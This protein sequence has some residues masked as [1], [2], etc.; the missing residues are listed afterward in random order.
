MEYKERVETALHTLYGD[1]SGKELPEYLELS[2]KFE[3]RFSVPVRHFFSSPGR[4]E[5]C[6]NH[7]DHNRGFVLAAAIDLDK[8]AAVAPRSDNI[9][10]IVTEDF[11]EEVSIDIG[12]GEI[13]KDEEG[14]SSSLVRGIAG[15]LR[16]KGFKTGGFSAYI[17]SRVAMGSGLSSSA[18]L[19]VLIGKIFSFLYND[20]EIDAVSLAL[21][22]QEAE[23]RFFGKPCGLMD[24]L[25]CASGGII[26][27]DFK[28]GSK[29]G[30]EKVNYQFS[31]RGYTLAIIHTGGNHADLTPDYA[32]IPEEMRSIARFFGKKECRDIT[33]E[34]VM[35]SLT[36]LRKSA[37]DRAV[38]R[39]LHFFSENSRVL[40]AVSALRDDRIDD[41]LEI[42]S[43]SGISSGRLLQNIFSPRVVD[44]QGVS[45]ALALIN[46]F[47]SAAGRGTCRVHG[48]GFAGTVQAY[49]PD[50]LFPSFREEIQRYF[51][52]G[53]VTAISIRPMGPVEL[54]ELS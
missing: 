2:R 3:E 38:L 34:I 36:E 21:T 43:A 16:K 20:N 52:N 24:Q 41:Y 4:T 30:V 37:G 26:A 50:T 53:S 1:K 54:S 17:R 47:I 31:S 28:D 7:T 48:G 29:P 25:A 12:S 39:A 46:S 15:I 13:R 8:I 35:G 23:N 19:E 32:A 11:P 44:E 33:R 40:D 51:G 6:G 45:I 10:E 5:L 14:T 22:G 42:I 49:I 27:V 18:S 9:V